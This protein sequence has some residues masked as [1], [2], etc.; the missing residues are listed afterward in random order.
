MVIR[1]SCTFQKERS[2][3]VATKRGSEFLFIATDQRVKYWLLRECFPS[4]LYPMDCP[5][6]LRQKY[7]W[8]D[9][10][11]YL[12][13]LSY[14]WWYSSC[15][16]LLFFCSRAVHLLPLAFFTHFGGG[17]HAMWATPPRKL[18]AGWRFDRCC[19]GNLR[20]RAIF[21]WVFRFRPYRSVRYWRSKAGSVKTCLEWVMKTEDRR[22]E[23]FQFE[24]QTTECTLRGILLKI[25]S[26]WT[27]VVRIDE[28]GS[29]RERKI[30]IWEKSETTKQGEIE[31]KKGMRGLAIELTII[32]IQPQLLHT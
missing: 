3:Q 1:P 16:L 18:Q 20:N 19:K 15:A 2:Y 29:K 21:S 11:W 10:R 27:V 14:L 22:K 6:C 31:I 24:I 25:A 5:D 13:P 28:A 4:H 9:G 12:Q 7:H 8:R 26:P 32:Y 30:R 23:W 17:I